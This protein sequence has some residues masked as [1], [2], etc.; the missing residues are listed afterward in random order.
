MWLKQLC[1][2]AVLALGLQSA[3]AEAWPTKPVRVIIPFAAGSATDIIPRTILDG[4]A[5]ELG[6]PI[7]VEN[8]GGGGGTIGAAVV[9]KS[10]PDGYTL[11]ATSSAHTISHAVF[12]NLPYD[13]ERDFTAVAPMG[14]SPN[15]LIISP[16]KGIRTAQELVAAAK[17]KPGSFNFASAGVG[18]ATHLSAER[19]RIAAGYEATHIPFKGGAEALTE[20]IAGRIEYYF[21]PLGTALPFIREGKVLALVVSTPTRVPALPDVPSALELFPNSDYPFWIGLFGPA[22]MPA[23]VVDRLNQATQKVLRSD[24]MKEKLAKLGVDPMFMSPAEF[25]GFVRKEIA[26]GGALAKAVGLKPN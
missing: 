7:V 15:V 25:A 22:R 19:F 20:V 18:T 11:L 23:D 17:A 2:L 10:D 6:Q 4:V 3:S 21:C 9:A 1:A 12:P 24:A 5:A 13:T 16:A 8:R 26:S 14:I